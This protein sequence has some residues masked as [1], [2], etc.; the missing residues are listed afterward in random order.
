MNVAIIPA[1]GSGKRLGGQIPKQFLALA[2]API[3]AHTIARFV[4]CADIG[5]IV[6]ALPA[7]KLAT[8]SY[9][10]PAKPILYVEG[11]VERSD[12]IGQ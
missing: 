9:P 6:V 3:L 7:D 4:E 1:A 5:L 8:F 2:G 10:T 12:S 11:G